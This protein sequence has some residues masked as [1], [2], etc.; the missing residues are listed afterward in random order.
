MSGDGWPTAGEGPRRTTVRPETR[1]ERDGGGRIC[2]GPTFGAREEDMRTMAEQAK[3]KRRY[4]AG[5]AGQGPAERGALTPLRR[6]ERGPTGCRWRGRRPGTATL[7]RLLPPAA[8]AL[9]R[10]IAR[11]GRASADTRCGGRAAARLGWRR[12]AGTALGP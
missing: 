11:S 7:A 4:T 6:P 5:R 12:R 10:R 2:G 8:N 3:K 1:P 9:D